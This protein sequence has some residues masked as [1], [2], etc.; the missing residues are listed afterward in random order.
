MIDTF[1][2]TMCEGS[3]DCFDAGRVA[4][5]DEM[6]ATIK[7]LERK[8]EIAEDALDF[9]ADHHSWVPREVNGGELMSPAIIYGATIAF[10]SLKQIRGEDGK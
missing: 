8:L 2:C 5:E 9:Y 3:C 6:Q 1:M 7:E 4:A 10:K